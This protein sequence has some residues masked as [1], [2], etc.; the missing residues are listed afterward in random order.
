MHSILSSLE[1]YV[2]IAKARP[3]QVLAIVI[4]DVTTGVLKKRNN[5][6]RKPTMS[7]VDFAALD[8]A[9]GHV[10]G[11]DQAAKAGIGGRKRD[12]AKKLIRVASGIDMRRLRLSSPSETTLSS[13]QQDSPR[14]QESV[15]SISSMASLD[16]PSPQSKSPGKTS[17]IKA[18]GPAVPPL[19]PDD[20][21]AIGATGP[22]S[23]PLISLDDEVREVEE[24]FQELSA[25][26]TKLLRRAAEWNERVTR[27]SQELPAGVRLLLFRE[28]AEVEETLMQLVKENR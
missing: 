27:L 17:P 25:T 4:R 10:D 23:D 2:A 9:L 19:G 14:R 5:P 22:S 26:Q 1:L 8:E 3:E 20:I 15:E 21:A 7:E 24:E 12:A 16:Q 13:G 11:H 6:S 18:S 28:P